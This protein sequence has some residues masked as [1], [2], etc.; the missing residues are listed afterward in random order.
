MQLSCSSECIKI[1]AVGSALSSRI[2]VEMQMAFFENYHLDHKTMLEIVIDA[3]IFYDFLKMAQPGDTLELVSSDGKQLDLIFYSPRSIMR[4]FKLNFLN[5]NLEP[6]IDQCS[7]FEFKSKFKINA[8]ELVRICNNMQL[9]SEVL[10]LEMNQN[11]IEF[12]ISNDLT[13]ACVLI[14]IQEQHCLDMKQSSKAKY[15]CK[16][17]NILNKTAFEIITI[18][19]LDNDSLLMETNNDTVIIKYFIAPHVDYVDW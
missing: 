1:T 10:Q 13:S 11:D 16:L 6:T 5:S 2:T 17:M 9:F 7:T 19:I 8:A 3:R 4:T 12:K 15:S 18:Y 14:P